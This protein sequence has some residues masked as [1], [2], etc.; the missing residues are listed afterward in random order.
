MLIN[1]LDNAANLPEGFIEETL[2]KLPEHKRRRFLLGEFGDA[3]GVIFKNWDIIENIP[4]EVKAHSRLSYGLDL[5]FSVDPAAVVELRMNGDDLYIDE[6]LYQTE[7]TNQQLAYELKRLGITGPLIADS[8]E[9]KSIRELSHAG[10][11]VK[12]AA[13]GPDSIRQGIDWLLSKKLHITRRSVSLQAELE[14]YC[15]RDN[16]E[17]K[18]IPEP[19]DDWNHCIAA[20]QRVLTARGLIPIED[21]TLDDMVMTREGYRRVIWQGQSGADAVILKVVTDNGVLYCT[22]D[23]KIYTVE[24]LTR[25]DALSYNNHVIGDK[26]W[27]LKSEYSKGISTGVTPIAE[28]NQTVG[29]SSGLL[30]GDQATCIGTYGNPTMALSPMATISI[31][32]MGIQATMIYQTLSVYLQKIIAP[33]TRGMK[34]GSGSIGSTLTESGHS[35]K[36]GTGAKREGTSTVKLGHSL[37]PAL[38]LS[39]SLAPIAAILSRLKSWGTWIYTVLTSARVPQEGQ[40]ELTMNQGNAP[41]AGPDSLPTSMTKHDAVLGRVLTVTE[42]GKAEKVYDLTIEH[43]H[44]FFCENILVSNSIDAIRYGCE[45]WRSAATVFIGRGNAAKRP[46]PESFNPFVKRV[47]KK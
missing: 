17:G 21:I 30:A 4:D 29:T 31:M 9:P 6:I 43:T 41:V 32:P 25:A 13:K 7:L 18:P 11:N 19:I 34:S 35:L 27:L 28:T 10:L 12:G 3:E 37:M 42:A 46:G 45:P 15:W 2:E 40:A 14:N 1:P 20:G 8:S 44:E 22:P 24:G 36:H 23:H 5:G 38:P 26:T 39:K 33:L 47:V 16:R